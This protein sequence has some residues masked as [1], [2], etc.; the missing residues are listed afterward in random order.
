MDRIDS[1]LASTKDD[2][3]RSK[4][5]AYKR[6]EWLSALLETGNEKVIAAYQK[7]E[8]INPAPIEH[9]GTLSKIEFW[10]G[11]TSPLT[12]EKLSSLSNAQ[13]A[14]YLI[15]F[16]ETEVFRKSDPTERGLAQTLERCVEASPQKFTDNLL[17][18]E[19]A[20][21]FY[22]SSLLHGFLKAWRDEKPFDWFALLKFICKILSFEHFWSVQYKVGFNYR[23]WILS[24][25]ADLIREGT[26]DDKRAFDVQFLTLAEEI[27]LIL[28]EKAEPSIFAPKDSSLDVLS[29]DRGKVFSAIVNYALRFARNSE[30]EDIGCRWPY[31]I[32]ADFTKRL[33]RSVETSLEFSYML[34]FY[35]PNLLY[36]DEQ[37]V[38][39]NIDRIFPQQNEDHWQAAF[40]GY[41]LGSRYPHTNLY[42][43]LKANGHYRKALNANFTDK[44]AQGRL[45]RHLCVGWI[46]DWETFDDDTSLIYQ[47]INSRNPNFLSAIVHF[48]FREGEALSQSSDS[49][50]IKAYEKVKAKVKPAWRALFKILF[51]NSDE[52]AY[53]RI[54]SPLSA[55]LGL[56]DEIDTEI[57]ESVKASIKYIDKAPGYGMTLS[58]VIEALTRHALITP[59]KVGKIYLEIPKSEMWYLQGVKKGDIEK[60]V[61]ILY[62]KGH[63]DIADKICNRFGEAG[64][65]FLRSVYEEYQR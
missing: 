15:N 49:E 1:G 29:S 13:I 4:S 21:S 31:A 42:V 5:I 58:R 45:V 39:G 43:W 55:W 17:P 47:L 26:K 37:W 34:G 10:T 18:F 28:V 51:R 23:N 20:S 53:Q 60:T 32:R 8:R 38:V 61:R 33:D 64:V 2:D 14:E 59:Q 22:Q 12:V 48:F 11:S 52:V 25:A 24:T 35:L 46:K 50:K 30:A 65:D 19:D 3:I 40:S 62:E 44:K 6:R 41:L 7:Y 56:V 36:L 57:L 63:K 27:L 54:L 16:K 9:P